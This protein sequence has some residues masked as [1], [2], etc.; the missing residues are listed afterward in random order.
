M[1]IVGKFDKAPDI[2]FLEELPKLEQNQII[3]FLNSDRQFFNAPKMVLSMAATCIARHGVPF[4]AS[5]F[6]AVSMVGIFST[7]EAKRKMG[8]LCDAGFFSR[9]HWKREEFFMPEAKFLE[10]VVTT[11]Y[12]IR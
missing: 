3:L 2:H 6:V 10:F 8:L 1:A 12:E 4:K 9:Y 11:P 7:W 5:D